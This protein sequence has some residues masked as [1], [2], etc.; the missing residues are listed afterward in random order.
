MDD[1]QEQL[2]V[3][4]QAEQFLRYIEE[5][6]YFNEL[7][8]RIKLTYAQHILTLH[9]SEKDKFAVLAERKDAIDEV[10]EAVRGDIAL[11]SMALKQ[12]EGEKPKG[13]L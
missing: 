6:P 12:I 7:L 8:E 4:R 13:L 10:I 5:N 11:A 2:E 3:G 9:P 1:L